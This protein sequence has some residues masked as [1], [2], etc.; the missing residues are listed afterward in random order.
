MDPLANTLII[1][2]LG[3]GLRAL[4]CEAAR[5][6]QATDMVGVIDD[7]KALTDQLSNPPTGPQGGRKPTSLRPG[8]NPSP[9][10]PALLRRQ[11]GGPTGSTPGFQA[12][13]PLLAV[14]PLPSPDRPPIDPQALGH[15]MGLQA[16]LEKLQSTKPPLF[17]LGRAAMWSHSVPPHSMIGHYLCRNQ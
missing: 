1:A 16:L 6:E 5:A 14:G 13:L 17:E 4:G 11:F 3:S 7:V 2:F 8:K 12:R 9:Q 10:S 15:N